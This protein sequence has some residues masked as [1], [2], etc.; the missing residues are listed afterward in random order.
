MAT[1]DIETPT[2]PGGATPGPVGVLPRQRG[3][4]PPARKQRNNVGL[5][6]GVAVL[7]LSLIVLI[8]LASVVQRSSKQGGDYFWRAVTTP[9]SWAA[10]KLT[11][12]GAALVA[13]INLI[14]GTVIAWVLVRDRFPGKAVVDTLIDLPFALPT[15]VA[16]LVLLA[17]YGTRSPLGVSVAYTRTGVML[18]LLFVTLPF[19]VRTV[20]PVLLELDRDAE[21]AA[22]SL[23]ASGWVTF[24]RI[25][26][27]NLMPAMISG[28]GLAFVRAL[29]EFGSTSLISG[30][31]PGQT[32]VAAVVIFGRIEGDDTTGAAAISTVLLGVSLVVLVVLDLVK[33]RAARRG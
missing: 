1:T 3:P 22:A 28:A 19:V 9:D 10:L 26:L 11:V 17:L 8:P 4:V 18:A 7:Y 12:G 5:G 30:N 25:I 21:Q 29:A 24:R 15:I 14:M 27:P 6:L 32:Q 13:I 33:R 20:Q 2:G 31:L 23:G 16:G